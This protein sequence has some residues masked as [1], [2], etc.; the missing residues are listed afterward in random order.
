MAAVAGRLAAVAVALLLRLGV[1]MCPG[2]AAGP[3]LPVVAP[4]V[5]GTPAWVP[6][7]P[8]GLPGC[9]ARPETGGEP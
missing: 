6:L 8:L 7:R 1:L 5:A 9:Y 3:V 4:L 2:A